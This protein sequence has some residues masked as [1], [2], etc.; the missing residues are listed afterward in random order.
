MQN[1]KKRVKSAI[2]V[3]F[4]TH[5]D[6]FIITLKSEFPLRSEIFPEK[7]IFS[8]RIFGNFHHTND[9]IIYDLFSSFPLNLRIEN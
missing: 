2:F 7:N 8:R 4:C 1:F 5:N 3:L 6:Y 9:H